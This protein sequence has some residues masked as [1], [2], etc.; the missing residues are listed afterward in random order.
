MR[1]ITSDDGHSAGNGTRNVYVQ[2][3]RLW[4]EAILIGLP[5]DD[6]CW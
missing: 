5:N 1:T 4:E 3:Q 6:R 2:E